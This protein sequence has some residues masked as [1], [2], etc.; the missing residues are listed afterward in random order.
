[1]AVSPRIVAS[2]SGAFTL[3]ELLVVIAIIALLIGVLLPAL[4]RARVAAQ[5]AECSSNL[6]QLT[7]AMLTHANENDGLL[8]TGPSDNRA[9]NGYGPIDQ[10]GW[11]ADMVNGEYAKPGDLLSPGHPAT[12]SQNIAFERLNSGSAWKNFDREEQAELVRRGINSNYCLAWYSAFTEA[13]AFFASAAGD[14]KDPENNKGPLKTQYMGKVA[15]SLVPLIGTG[16]TD[17]EGDLGSDTIDGEYG[18]LAKALTDGPRFFGGRYQRQDYTDFGPSHGRRQA[19]RDQRHGSRWGNIAFA[20]G[21][22]DNF[23]DTA[24]APGSADDGKP[25][26]VFGFTFDFTNGKFFYHDDDFEQKVFGGR[27]LSGD[28]LDE[29]N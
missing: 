25:D 7:V 22:V 16:S 29:L 19:S 20:D 23:E 8:C 14:V 26:G 1:M 12:F 3:V 17:D 9:G 2:R 24:S 10:F 21:H 28:P 27:I 13:K 4:G 11:M 5:M 18:L 6:R 15:S